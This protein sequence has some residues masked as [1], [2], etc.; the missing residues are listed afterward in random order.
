LTPLWS[1]QS[2]E[3]QAGGKMPAVI[4]GTVALLGM[5]YAAAKHFGLLL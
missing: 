4:A 2:T 1:L 5:L 3:F